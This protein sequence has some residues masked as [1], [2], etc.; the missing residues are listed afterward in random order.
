ML[1]GIA[2]DRL[3]ILKVHHNLAKTE[4]EKF[5][6]RSGGRFKVRIRALVATNFGYDRLSWGANKD[7]K[8]SDKRLFQ[9]GASLSCVLIPNSPKSPMSNLI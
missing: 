4:S 2:I 3:D 6:T 5:L 7:V 8:V 9:N 1:Q